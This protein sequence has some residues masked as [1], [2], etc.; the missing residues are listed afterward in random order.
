[1]RILGPIAMCRWDPADT[2]SGRQVS[3]ILIGIFKMWSESDGAGR[4]NLLSKILH[5]FPICRV[6]CLEQCLND[7]KE[8]HDAESNDP[9][10]QVSHIPSLK[11]Y[12]SPMT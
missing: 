12:H 11:I 4:K 1:M 6:A 2:S 8:I 9:L 10:R 3:L 7:R 5:R